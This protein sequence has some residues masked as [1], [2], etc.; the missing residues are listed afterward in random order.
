MSR[1]Q[2][3]SD[4][5]FD[6]AYLVALDEIYHSHWAARKKR[7]IAFLKE[8]VDYFWPQGHPSQLLHIT[9]TNGKGSTAFY[10]AQ[11]LRFAGNTGTWTS[12]HVFDYAERF[13]ING[14]RADHAEIVTVYREI[15][16]PYQ[17]AFV[18][19]HG[20]ES[21]SFA[22][23]G[24]LLALHLF[25][26]HKVRWAVMEVGAGGRY[27]QLMALKM[28]AC[29]LTN[30]DEDHPKSLGSEPWQRA[31]E[32]AGIARP[33]VP[34]F[35]GAE[36]QILEWV[37]ATATSQGAPV[38]A[39][40]ATDIRTVADTLDRPEADYK[41]R[42]MALAAAVI[43]HFYPDQSTASLLASMQAELPARFWEVAPHVIADVAHNPGKI[44]KLVERLTLTYPDKRYRLIL[45]LTRS[46]DAKRVFAPLLARADAVTLT[47]ASYA[48]QDPEELAHTLRELCPQVQVEPDPQQAYQLARDQREANQLVVLTGSAYMIDQALNPN[49]YIRHLNAN[50]GWRSPQNSHRF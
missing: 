39:V 40:T 24:I 48:G 12:P 14:Q 4:A 47:G 29:I 22:E 11:G 30:V 20:G 10:L 18:E 43:R 33:Q 2:D 5:H 8:A 34:F 25:D 49:P 44:A 35:T 31:L 42:N 1:E 45:G 46:R 7:R 27:T 16:E 15:L 38:H 17:A 26:R 21:L 3:R 36:D 9:G 37:R 13:H 6:P 50:Y 41:L 32:K 19:R 23:L 28:A